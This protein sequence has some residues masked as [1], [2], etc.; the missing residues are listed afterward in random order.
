MNFCYHAKY[1]SIT[2]MMGG[3][4]NKKQSSKNTTTLIGAIMKFAES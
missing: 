1:Q 2:V 4:N 3:E